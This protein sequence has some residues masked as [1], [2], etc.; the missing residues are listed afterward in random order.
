M[1]RTVR[2][3]SP[4]PSPGGEGTE[5]EA[6]YVVADVG[7]DCLAGDGARQGAQNCGGEGADFLRAPP[8]APRGAR[9]AFAPPRVKIANRRRRQRSRGA[10]ADCVDADILAA[11]VDRQVA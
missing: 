4:S 9:L 8:T 1:L 3:P 11:E 7:I 10:G 5:L 2:A 6:G